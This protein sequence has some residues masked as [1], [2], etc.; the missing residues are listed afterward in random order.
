MTLDDQEVEL[1]R[2]RTLWGR[3]LALVRF[4]TTNELREVP[5]DQ[6]QSSTL[7]AMAHYRHRVIATR[8]RAELC[9]N[10]RL[11][12][13]EA[14]ILPLPHQLLALEKV[15]SG[16]QVRHLLAD[17]V[18]MGKTIETGLVI[19]EL[20]LRGL[21]KRILVITPLSALEQ[22]R[23][24]LQKH[25]HEDFR[26]YGSEL[27]GAMAQSFGAVQGDR[28]INPWTQSDQILVSMDAIK[29]M[30]SRR[31]WSME[32]LR[33]Y[34]RFRLEAILEAGFDLVVI[35]ECHK[36]G[37]SD[38][39]VARYQMAEALC[40]VS[41]HVLLLSA[42]PHR[43]K[44]DHFR[45]VLSLLDPDVFA[46]EGAPPIAL[47]EP[48]VV[49][50]EKRHAIDFDGKKLFN[51]RHTERQVV[52]WTDEN[53]ARQKALYNAV[54]DYV[55]TGFNQAQA[56]KDR[57][58]GLV[59]ILF[60]RIASSS[61]QAIHDALAGRRLRLANRPQLELDEEQTSLQFEVGLAD[62]VT[63]G[64]PYQGELDKLD[65]LIHQAAECL[66]AEL[67]AKTEYLLERMKTM[68]EQEGNPSLKFL[69]FTE[70]TATQSM[71]A[72]VLASRGGYLCD[73]IDG[74]MDRAERVTALKRFR[75]ETQ[76][77]IC[78]DAA[79]ESLNMQFA[80]I[81]VNYDLPWNPMVLEQRIGRV[82]RIGQK[83][84]VLALNLLL[85][86]PVDIRVSEV[87]ETKLQIILNELGIDKTADVLD[88][89]MDT[90]DVEKLYL[91]SLINP[92]EFDQKGKEWLDGIRAK[93]Q[94]YRSTES[95]LP[96]TDSLAVNARRNDPLHITP[97]PSWVQW[98]MQAYLEDRG[99]Q[100]NP[101]LLGL[102]C[103]WQ[104][105]KLQDFTFDARVAMDHP[106]MEHLSLQHSIVQKMLQDAH[107]A[108]EEHPIPVCKV[109]PSL[110][111]PNYA[112]T[113]SV[114]ELGV[115][116]GLQQASR[117]IPIFQADSGAVYM[118]M[119][120]E[121]WKQW[122]Q[123]PDR[124]QLESHQTDEASKATM[125]SALQCAETRLEPMFRE[126]FTQVDQ[127]IR[128]SAQ[129]KEHAWS[130][131]EKQIKRLGLEAVKD[132]RLRLLQKERDA[133]QEN[134]QKG[135]RT[136]PQLRCWVIARMEPAC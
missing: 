97:I 38:D 104:G 75:E 110:L 118:P 58:L 115:H 27:I 87:I 136:I 70:F 21:A 119:A 130:F 129:N 122:I 66:R 25:F 63:Q 99:W 109:D 5:L 36:V 59:M 80:H 125:L 68:R 14:S 46:G 17:E 91:A 76:V 102:Q 111:P 39:L 48:Y 37:G 40:R 42:T 12:P 3:E 28:F 51:I 9:S 79:G 71:L 54:C 117:I 19:K 107:T 64:G 85:D 45:R 126:I 135:S 18:G 132:F 1:L 77:L 86:S 69:I 10:E 6:L 82:D 41:P 89:T 83:H 2:T 123:Q 90:G 52:P 74:S 8:I 65:E 88:S 108:I 78:T 94:N 20:K 134:F 95:A 11:A 124:F 31:G 35:D 15:L 55:R 73:R 114:W 30:E 103:Q 23:D 128:T 34:N 112:G 24:E 92:Q 72:Q 32:K 61:T 62:L 93:L 81:V 67:D 84:E 60:Q 53:H 100:W 57:S 22:W 7:P 131:Q 101:T 43:G 113:W 50:T 96:S 127:Q 121:L 33:E 56:S 106:G 105:G 16:R 29:P 120:Q 44:P 26:I 98:M 47:L 4:L 133:W 49:R 13:W 116:S